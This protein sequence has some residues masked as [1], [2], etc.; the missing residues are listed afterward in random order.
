MVEE[1]AHPFQERTSNTAEHIMSLLNTHGDRHLG[2][3]DFVEAVLKRS[4]E[5]LHREAELHT[6]VAKLGN[7]LVPHAHKMKEENH[8]EAMHYTF[9]VGGNQSS[10]WKRGSNTYTVTLPAEGPGSCTC[11][12]FQGDVFPCDHAFAHAEKMNMPPM[13]LVRKYAHNCYF[14]DK[15]FGDKYK[16]NYVSPPTDKMLTM[17]MHAQEA[18]ATTGDVSEIKLLKQ[19]CPGL[20]RD[21]DFEPCTPPESNNVSDRH[22]NC[23]D[24][25]RIPGEGRPAKKLKTTKKASTTM[26]VEHGFNRAHLACATC[27]KEG[28]KGPYIFNHRGRCPHTDANEAKTIVI[29]DSSDDEPSSSLT[30]GLAGHNV[31]PRVGELVVDADHT[32]APR[33]HFPQSEDDDDDIYDYGDDGDDDD[34]DDQVTINIMERKLAELKKRSATRYSPPPVSS[35]VSVRARACVLTQ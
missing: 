28:R 23:K 34:D 15:D 10:T 11:L 26:A 6:K 35:C 2:P 31:T 27:V 29:E 18:E 16:L 32:R 30:A 5:A 25:R 7:E 8:K 9:V 22:G 19:A 12:E 4:C 33:L 1:G 17:L 24:K 14:V 21:T 20:F 13:I 3:F